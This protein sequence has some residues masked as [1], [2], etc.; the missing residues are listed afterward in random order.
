MAELSILRGYRG[1]KLFNEDLANAKNRR[2]LSELALELQ[3]GHRFISVET[4]Q[5]I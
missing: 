4:D 1:Q 2:K 5:R 3:W